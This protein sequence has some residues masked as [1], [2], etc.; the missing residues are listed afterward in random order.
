MFK[1]H[2]SMIHFDHSFITTNRVIPNV[3][4]FT[5]H[6]SILSTV[7]FV[8]V[9]SEQ[10]ATVP[11]TFAPNQPQPVFIQA[12]PGLQPQ[13]PF[14]QSQPPA[15]YVQPQYASASNQQ[16]MMYVGVHQP[17]LTSIKF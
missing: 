9:F 6:L 2:F 8:C 10:F 17:P 16:Q 5:M 7:S 12:P 1:L 3:F 13:P 15:Y 11:G 14:L 4:C